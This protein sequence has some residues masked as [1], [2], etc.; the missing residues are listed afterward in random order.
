MASLGHNELRVEDSIVHDLLEPDIT[1]IEND[2][3]TELIALND[4]V[5]LI[6]KF[7]SNKCVY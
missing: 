5:D 6:Q 1:W 4:Y 7:V 2:Q 3:S